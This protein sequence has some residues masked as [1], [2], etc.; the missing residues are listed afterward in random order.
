MFSGTIALFWFSGSSL[1]QTFF[2]S[3][4]EPTVDLSTG[5]TSNPG[6]L[7]IETCYNI[8]SGVALA[9]LISSISTS[10]WSS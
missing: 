3:L 10:S 5:I 7:R 6:G 1:I 8:S 4:R 9:L 2:L